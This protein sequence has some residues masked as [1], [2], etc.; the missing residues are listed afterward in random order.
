MYLTLTPKPRPRGYNSSSLEYIYSV[1][2]VFGT[3]AKAEA[4]GLTR[5][6]WNIS[7]QFIMHLALTPKPGTDPRVALGV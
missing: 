6:P 4:V 3:Q 2:Y 7:T 5:A 1:H